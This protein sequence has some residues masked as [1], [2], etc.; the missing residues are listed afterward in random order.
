MINHL[1]NSI[2]H[3]EQLQIVLAIVDTFFDLLEAHIH[4]IFFV[5]VF[6]WL[7]A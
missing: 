5:I 3:L 2:F 6:S 1:D 4:G 7:A